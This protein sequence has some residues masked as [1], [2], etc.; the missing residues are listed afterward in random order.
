MLVDLISFLRCFIAF[1]VSKKK[2]F[3]LNSFI[4]PATQNNER[5]K[6]KEI[7]WNDDTNHATSKCRDWLCCCCFFFVIVYQQC[8]DMGNRIVALSMNRFYFLI[9]STV[10]CRSNWTFGAWFCV[11]KILICIGLVSVFYSTWN[12]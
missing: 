8:D 9:F 5:R 2:F 11:N 6:K 7:K 10:C 4:W 1:G 12:N 3:L